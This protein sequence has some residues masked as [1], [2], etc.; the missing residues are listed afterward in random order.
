MRLEFPRHKHVNIKSSF[1]KRLELE[2]IQESIATLCN[3]PDFGFPIMLKENEDTTN[4]MRTWD[5][6]LDLI[7]HGTK[8]ERVENF[9][10]A[11]HYE[12]A[13][14]AKEELKYAQDRKNQA[15]AAGR[16]GDKNQKSDQLKAEIE[17]N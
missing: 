4:Y 10:H 6:F 13:E 3:V 2:H 15:S 12:I 14:E 17:G 11:K 5:L 1:I 16:A 7:Q 8:Y 9:I